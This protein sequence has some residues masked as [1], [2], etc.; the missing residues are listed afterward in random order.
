MGKS[1]SSAKSLSSKKGMDTAP[2]W[3]AGITGGLS[4]LS[5]NA[6]RKQRERELQAQMDL[7]KINRERAA[8]GRLL[9]AT[10]GFDI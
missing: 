1:T 8:I 3:A 4:V 7:E 6:A 2:I 5:A 10:Q 9:Q